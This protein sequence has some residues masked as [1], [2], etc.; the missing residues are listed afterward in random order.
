MPT[1]VSIKQEVVR[2]ANKV[3]SQHVKPDEAIKDLKQNADVLED[4]LIL[5]HREEASVIVNVQLNTYQI[6]ACQGVCCNEILINLKRK[7]RRRSDQ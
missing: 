2:I 7:F 1:T 4:M 5:V 3:F 6:N